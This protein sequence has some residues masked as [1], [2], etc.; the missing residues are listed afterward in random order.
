MKAALDNRGVKTIT[1]LVS[2]ETDHLIEK[3]GIIEAKD[4]EEV[5]EVIQNYFI[6][7]LINIVDFGGRGGGR[8]GSRGRGD[9]SRGDRGGRGGGRGGDRF[10]G[11]R[12]RFDSKGRFDKDRR[13][14]SSFRGRER[15][16]SK[17]WDRD[18]KSQ[19][20][21]ENWADNTAKATKPVDDGWGG[22]SNNAKP[23]EGSSDNWSFILNNTNPKPAA[24]TQESFQKDDIDY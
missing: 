22:D 9:S 21:E 20:G 2:I 6:E 4:P 3:I 24:A 19:R 5:A 18:K 11:G 12:E 16:R 13:D 7:K 23:K 15:S 14:N 10:D 17:S 1:D 8:G